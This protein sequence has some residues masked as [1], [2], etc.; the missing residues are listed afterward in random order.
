[1]V[2]SEQL[3]VDLTI[4]RFFSRWCKV[5]LVRELYELCRRGEIGR[6]DRLKI[7]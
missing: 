3:R 1:M 2:I 7:Y 6:H 5:L 4:L